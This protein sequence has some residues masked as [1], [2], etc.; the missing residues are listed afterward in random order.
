MTT[1]LG[2]KHRFVWQQKKNQR[3]IMTFF[4]TMQCKHLIT[5]IVAIL[6]ILQ[7]LLT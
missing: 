1:R 4:V 7:I 2:L 3:Y 5:K 6:E